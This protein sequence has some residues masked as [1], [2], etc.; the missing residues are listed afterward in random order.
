MVLSVPEQT[1]KKPGP[2]HPKEPVLAEEDQKKEAKKQ[3]NKLRKREV[4][5]IP[6]LVIHRDKM[7]F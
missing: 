1:I 4:G 3:E 7:E 2:K 5:R 6:N